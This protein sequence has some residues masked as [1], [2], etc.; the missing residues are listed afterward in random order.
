MDSNRAETFL[1]LAVMQERSKDIDGAEQSYLKAVSLELKIL[2]RPALP[3]N[4]LPTPEALVGCGKTV[5]SRDRS[6]SEKRVTARVLA[7]LYLNEGKPD[8]AEKSLQDAKGALADNPTGYRMLAELYL[9]QT[10]WDKALAELAAL[11]SEHPKD[12][13]VAK[14]YAELLLQQNRLDDASK[15]TDAL[16]KNSPLRSRCID[17]AGPALDS[18]GKSYR[19]RSCLG[20][21]RE[22]FSG[23]RRC[24]LSIGNGICRHTKYGPSRIRMAAGV[25]T[26]ARHG[27]TTP[28][29]CRPC[30]ATWRRVVARRNRR[31]AYDAGTALS[32]RLRPARS[33]SV[34]EK[35]SGRRGSG[36][37]ASDQRRPGQCRR[38]CSDRRFAHDSKK[39]RRSPEVLFRS[40]AAKSIRC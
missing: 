15:V 8:A 25:Q 34:N 6:G 29:S 37:E 40:V 31:K 14:M 12:P 28:C 4:F 21:S 16:L 17:A 10:Q 32:G 38:L 35:G 24:S 2:A 30:H 26:P 39:I 33:R 5:S 7:G 36:S 19:R 20:T 11:Y 1:N 13:V 27:G 18:S 9:G 3:G 22:K 23:Q